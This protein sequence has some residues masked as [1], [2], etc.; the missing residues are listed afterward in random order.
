MCAHPEKNWSWSH[1]SKKKKKTVFESYQHQSEPWMQWF[2]KWHWIVGYA[3]FNLKCNDMNQFKIV[4]QLLTL[5]SPV[6]WHKGSSK[7]TASKKLLPGVPPWSGG[8]EKQHVRT[9][10]LLIFQ[11]DVTRAT[12]CNDKDKRLRTDQMWQ[13]IGLAIAKST[14][15]ATFFRNDIRGWAAAFWQPPAALHRPSVEF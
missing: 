6:S 11:T 2:L 10:L 1:W 8:E 3:F 13:H 4:V 7:I 5:N 12:A 9:L 15:T 14:F